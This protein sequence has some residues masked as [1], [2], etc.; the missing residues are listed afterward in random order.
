[1]LQQYV[2]DELAS[3][4]AITPSHIGVTVENGVVTLRGTVRAY[5]E[6]V[7]A[8]RAAKRVSGVRALTDELRVEIHALHQRDDRDIAKAVTDALYWDVTVPEQRIKAQVDDGWVTLEGEVDWD[9]QIVNAKRAVQFLTGV[10]G[11][12]SRI[13]L[14]HSGAAADI[15]TRLVKTFKRSAEI[16]ADQIEIEVAGDRVILRGK[17]RSW[18]EHE[19]AGR[20]ARSIPGVKDVENM[21]YVG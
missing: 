20:A 13:A 9:Y 8:E 10:R 4:P 21:T 6:K 15:K 17:V 19:D 2:L 11:I 18:N 16:D 3:D 7:L 5:A 1:M 14:K 12:T